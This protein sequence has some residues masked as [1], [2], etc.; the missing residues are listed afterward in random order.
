MGVAAEHA[1]EVVGGVE[2]GFEFGGAAGVPCA[3]EGCVAG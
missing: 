2:G 1:E 3:A